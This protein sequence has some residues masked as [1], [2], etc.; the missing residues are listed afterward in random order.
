MPRI[1]RNPHKVP[2]YVYAYVIIC[3]AHMD[4]T[5]NILHA[6]KCE[7]LCMRMYKYKMQFR[8]EFCIVCC[9]FFSFSVCAVGFFSLTL[10]DFF[11]ARSFNLHSISL[12]RS[13]STAICY[14]TRIKYGLSKV[15]HVN[16]ESDTH[17]HS[18]IDIQHSSA[19]SANKQSMKC[20]VY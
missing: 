15:V 2:S 12:A 16:T 8:F 20:S 10:C 3:I 7:K 13:L 14:I 6:S 11:H 1:M 19:L 17:T 9:C 5:H 4:V 18:Y